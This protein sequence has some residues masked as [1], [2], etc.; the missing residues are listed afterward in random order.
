MKQ[1]SFDPVS[2]VFG[3]VFLT[4]AVGVGL[5]STLGWVFGNIP[6]GFI[7]PV[8]LIGVGGWMLVA[9]VLRQRDEDTS[10][11]EAT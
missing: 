4:L 5:A 10:E 2:F 11:P 9:A 3:L 6:F 1:H 8:L 7:G